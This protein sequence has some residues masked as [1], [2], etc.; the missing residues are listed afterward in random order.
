MA[1]GYSAQNIGN[2]AKGLLNGAQSAAQTVA[3][4]V[5][6]NGNPVPNSNSDN[7]VVLLQGI[8]QVLNKLAARLAPEQRQTP[9]IINPLASGSSLSIAQGV[10]L[11]GMSFNTIVGTCEGTGGTIDVWLNSSGSIGVPDF[12]FVGGQGTAQFFFPATP[13]QQIFVKN[14]GVGVATGRIVLMQY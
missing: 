11:N 13:L 7:A 5:Q 2:V 3:N 8:L 14:N 6:G 4:A 10:A 12:S 9:I 1:N